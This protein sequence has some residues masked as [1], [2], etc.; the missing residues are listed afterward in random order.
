LNISDSLNIPT[1]HES[2][3]QHQDG[4]NLTSI[5]DTAYFLGLPCLVLKSINRNFSTCVTGNPVN[6]LFLAWRQCHLK[7]LLQHVLVIVLVLV[8]H[9]VG[10]ENLVEAPLIGFCAHRV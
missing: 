8:D 5:F 10:Q 1:A 9:H 3:D 2:D 6:D 7:A 4:G